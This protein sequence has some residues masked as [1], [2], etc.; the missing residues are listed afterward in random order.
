[1]TWVMR[2]SWLSRTRAA[3]PFPH[4]VPR[5]RDV[6]T[7]S[8]RAV[9]ASSAEV[10]GPYSTAAASS[11]HSRR[12]MPNR[13]SHNRTNTGLACDQAWYRQYMGISARW[14]GGCAGTEGIVEIGTA[15]GREK[16]CQDV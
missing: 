13:P 4:S 11:L 12:V 3:Q 1:M 6:R 5:A 9:A 7:R 15:S 2:L 16:D 8:S 10:S 14:T